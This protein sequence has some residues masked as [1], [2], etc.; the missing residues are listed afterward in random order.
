MKPMSRPKRTKRV[1]K[2]QESLE[3]LRERVARKLQVNMAKTMA[4]IINAQGEM[5]RRALETLDAVLEDE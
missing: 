3:E 1:S 2:R 4:R 5:Q